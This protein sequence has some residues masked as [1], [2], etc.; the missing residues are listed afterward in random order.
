MGKGDITLTTNFSSIKDTNQ[1]CNSI[2][3]G[4]HYYSYYENCE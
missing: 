3:Y 1:V 4:V 2:H